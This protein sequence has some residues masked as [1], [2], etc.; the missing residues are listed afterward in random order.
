MPRGVFGGGTQ[1]HSQSGSRGTEVNVGKNFY[2]GFCGTGNAEQVC[3]GLDSL[4][5][6]RAFWGS[7]TITCCLILGPGV[8]R[9][10]R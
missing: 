8:I 4:N 6:L 10:G 5:D 1:H 3:L 9:A 2:Y 7:R